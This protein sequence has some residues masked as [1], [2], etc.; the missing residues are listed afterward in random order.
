L[1]ELGVGQF[2]VPAFAD[3]HLHLLAM[4]AA[5]LSVDADR[6]SIGDVLAAISTAAAEQGGGWIRAVGYDDALI[7]ERR[8]P[9]R[10]ELDAASGGHPT[11]LHHRTGHAAVLNS[12]ALEAIG[13]PRSGDGLLVDRHDLLAR[14]PAVPRAKLEGA[15]DKVLTQLSAV[16]VVAVTDATHTNDAAAIAL[17]D[18]PSPIAVTAMVG[19]DRLDGLHHGELCGRV[20]I[21]PAKVMPALDGTVLG[22]NGQRALG[23]AVAI[24][25]R[26]GFPAAVHVTDVEVLAATIEAFEASPSPEGLPDRIEHCSLALPEQLDRLAGLSVEVVTQPSFVTRRATKYRE[27]LSEIEQEWLWPAASLARRG[28]SLRLSSDAPVAP[29]DPCE[30]LDS[31]TERDINPAERLTLA[32]ALGAATIGPFRP[33]SDPTVVILRG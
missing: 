11:V 8:H 22:G 7:A 30:W 12:A 24:A 29:A 16:G 19:W 33:G 10:D 27:Q 5:R 3:S 25:H 21:G 1:I 9:T 17:L 2:A 28:V 31:A 26:A 4:A 23:E 18:R 6:S 15:L 14:V 20:R 13:L 32:E